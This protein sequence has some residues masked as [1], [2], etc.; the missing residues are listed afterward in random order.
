M[1]AQGIVPK[2]HMSILKVFCYQKLPT[3]IWSIL[4]TYKKYFLLFHSH[5][6]IH[7]CTL[8]I[9][10]HVMHTLT[11]IWKGIFMPSNLHLRGN[12]T[13]YIHF[14]KHSNMRTF[15]K[16]L[17]TYSTYT[18]LIWRVLSLATYPIHIRTWW[19]TSL[20]KL[21]KHHGAAPKISR[22]PKGK[23]LS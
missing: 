1:H 6:F 9:P 15:I 16:C 13:S 10:S 4:L 8:E 5:L 18:R 23:P 3:H 19:I 14:G 12:S 2:L 20:H 11:F 22:W 21:S 17:T 7:I